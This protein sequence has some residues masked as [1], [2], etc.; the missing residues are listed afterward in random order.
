MTENKPL[1][2]V[3]AGLG[4]MGRSHA[5]AYATNPGFEIAALV[6]RSDV[7]LSGP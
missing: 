4:N 3:V 7:P 5:L 6:N 1:R 2:V